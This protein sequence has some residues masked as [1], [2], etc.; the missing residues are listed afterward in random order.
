MASVGGYCA[1]ESC[2]GEIIAFD[3]NPTNDIQKAASRYKIAQEAFAFYFG[4]QYVDDDLQ[5]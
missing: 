1:V 5:E 2:H 4:K 3:A